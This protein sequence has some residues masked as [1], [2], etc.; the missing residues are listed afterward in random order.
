[1]ENTTIRIKD[2]GIAAGIAVL[3]LMAFAFVYRSASDRH[4]LEKLRDQNRLLSREIHRLEESFGAIRNYTKSAD[5]L[6][7]RPVPG[8]VCRVR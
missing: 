5:R 4:E 2:K 3:T 6:A 7:A 8:F 1:M